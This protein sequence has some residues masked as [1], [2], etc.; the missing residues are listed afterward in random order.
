M[1]EKTNHSENAIALSGS[2]KSRLAG[3]EKTISKGWETFLAVGRALST[4]REERLYREDYPTFEAYCLD[5]WQMG[6]SHASR[7]IGAVEIIEELSENLD[8]DTPLPQNEAQVRCLKGLNTEQ[9]VEFWGR[10]MEERDESPL[11]AKK[12]RDHLREYLGQD[13]VKHHNGKGA[14]KTPNRIIRQLEMFARE[15]ESM[16]QRE[17]SQR[18]QALYEETKELLLVEDR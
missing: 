1:K 14:L 15:L 3:L 6:R 5:K 18:Y 17:L 9:R 13:D 10:L 12:I 11:T 16:G 2:E 8:D 4:I 7:L